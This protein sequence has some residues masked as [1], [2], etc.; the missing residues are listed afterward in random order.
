[1]PALHSFVPATTRELVLSAGALLLVGV[2][3]TMQLLPTPREAGNQLEVYMQIPEQL[4]RPATPA[5]TSG[6]LPPASFK[7]ANQDYQDWCIAVL[8]GGS[9]RPMVKSGTQAGSQYAQDVWVYRNFF[10]KQQAEEGWTGFYVESGANDAERLSNT[11]FFDVCL[12]WQGLC[13]EPMRRYHAGLK[14]KRTCTLVPEC[15]SSTTEVIKMQD[16]EAMS[17]VTRDSTTGIDVQCRPF[18]DIL[19]T[20]GGGRT[21]ADFWSLDVEGF[22]MVVLAAVDFQKVTVGALLIEDFWSG[23]LMLLLLLLL[24]VRL[25]LLLTYLCMHHRLSTRQLDYQ[26]SQAGY[27][28]VQQL[29]LDSLYMRRDMS[30]PVQLW[31]P[32]DWEEYW[33]T[34]TKFR[35]QA[36]C[37]HSPGSVRC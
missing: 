3:A 13:I 24:L 21:H 9:N 37:S 14:S 36:K 34:N 22:E 4:R 33:I 25:L 28:K 2:I 35:D 10:T 7:A 8:A 16:S 11:L 20:Y 30:L 31:Y 18:V 12:G 15:I 5:V 17:S 19:Q 27:N 29:A 23:S 26:L 32:R 1:M 6:V